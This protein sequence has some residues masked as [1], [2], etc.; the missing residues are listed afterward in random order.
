[1]KEVRHVPDM[2]KKLISKGQ[3]GGEGYVTTFID[4]TYKITK[5]ALIIEKGEK[6]GTL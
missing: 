1:L 2:K 4:K 3:L 5:G 6:V